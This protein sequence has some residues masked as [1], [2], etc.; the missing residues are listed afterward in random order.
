MCV[1]PTDLATCRGPRVASS[2][3]RVQAGSFGKQGLEEEKGGW[4]QQPLQSTLNEGAPLK[5]EGG[6][7]STSGGAARRAARGPLLS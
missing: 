6:A 7:W 1:T 5:P 3:C 4:G 2:N